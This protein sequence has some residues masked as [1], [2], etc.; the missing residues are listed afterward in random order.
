MFVTR[1]LSKGNNACKLQ[2]SVNGR[3]VKKLK[4]KKLTGIKNHAESHL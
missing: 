3:P 1:S 4:S 2:D